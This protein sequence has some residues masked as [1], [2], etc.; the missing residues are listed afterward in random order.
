[1]KFQSDVPSIPIDSCRHQHVLMFQ[2]ISLRDTT[3]NAI[4]IGKIGESLRLELNFTFPLEQTTEVFA[5]GQ[6]LS[7]VA[8]EKMERTFKNGSCCSPV[9]SQSFFSIQVSVV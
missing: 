7:A 8:L 4:I 5:L 2:L 3:E 6:R 9:K 1:M